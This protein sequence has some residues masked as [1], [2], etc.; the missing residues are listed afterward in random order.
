MT[1][2]MARK[3]GE[4][5]LLQ[6]QIARLQGYLETA[7]GQVEA[8]QLRCSNL[9]REAECYRVSLENAGPADYEGV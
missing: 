2:E 1:N 4:I 3:N 7:E 5:V 9:E 6:A 8:L